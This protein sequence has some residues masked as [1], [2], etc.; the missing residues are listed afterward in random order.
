MGI[1]PGEMGV[2]M[3][4][5][6]SITALLVACFAQAS[7]GMGMGTFD[8]LKPAITENVAFHSLQDFIDTIAEQLQEKLTL[9][10]DLAKQ[11]Q[12]NITQTNAHLLF[13]LKGKKLGPLKSS[14]KD[15]I[16]NI[17]DRCKESKT[18]T[19]SQLLKKETEICAENYYV[20]YHSTQPSIYAIHY[21]DTKLFMLYQK[22]IYHTPINAPH[23]LKLRQGASSIPDA[24]HAETRCRFIK[25]G[26]EDDWQDREFLLSCNSALSGNVVCSGECTLNYWLT[27]DNQYYF[28]YKIENLLNDYKELYDSAKLYITQLEAV[29]NEMSTHCKTGVLLQ[30]IFKTPSLVEECVYSAKLCGPK[31]PVTLSSGETDNPVT[32]LDA[33]RHNPE[34]FQTE[35]DDLQFRVVLTKDKLLDIANPDIYNNFEVHPYCLPQET[36]EAFHQ[37]VNRIMQAIESDYLQH[38]QMMHLQ[39]IDHHG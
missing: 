3:E 22:L 6:Y 25:N 36:L 13:A 15:L 30:L 24:K 5:K 38:M 7:F 29:I 17:L 26:A 32:I 9:A 4:K 28:S 37:E 11:K 19:I 12:L 16:R 33:L 39:G 14:N 8:A 31:N 2:I 35:I 23:I 34:S 18:T 1:F 10:K 20:L 27:S 21:I